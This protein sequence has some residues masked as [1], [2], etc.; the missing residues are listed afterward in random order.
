MVAVGIDVSKG[1]STVAVCCEGKKLLQ[2]PFDVFHNKREL[3]KR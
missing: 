3:G 1:R 2:K